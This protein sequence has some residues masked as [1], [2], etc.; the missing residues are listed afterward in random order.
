MR[1]FAANLGLLWTDRP[2]PDR[3]AA[4]AKAGFSAVEMHWPYDHDPAVVRTSAAHNGV[5]LL[6][7][8]SPPGV[9]A[10]GDMGL[11]AVPGRQ[12]DFRV[13]MEQA[14]D[15]CTKSGATAIHVMAG[16]V[17]EEHRAEGAAVFTENLK[18]AARLAATAGLTI[19]VEPLNR[20]DHPHYFYHRVA[21][22]SAIVEKLAAT[23][24]KIQF[25]TYHVALEGDAVVDALERHW[26]FI[27]H[28]QI[29]SAPDRSEPIG[30][31]IDHAEVMRCLHRLGYA[32]WVAGEY[33]PRASTDEGLE[34]LN[35]LSA[36]IPGH[37]ANASA[38]L[39]RPR[40]S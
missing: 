13:G 4:A 15:Y 2:L 10:D 34:W 17:S 8:N 26:P 5:T 32:G 20:R 21:E 3:I 7:I 31:Q 36:T 37:P 33:R 18:E 27:G 35:I 12:A 25:D 1:G 28:I 24:V 40:A 39:V 22:A 19:L 16:N 6:G 14:V 9:I 30:G 29:A 11:G 38:R 23:N